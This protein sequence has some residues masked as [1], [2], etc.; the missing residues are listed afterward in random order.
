[1]LLFQILEGSCTIWAIYIEDE[2]FAIENYP[3]IIVLT[4][5]RRNDHR[6]GPA[7]VLP[8]A[9]GGGGAI[10]NWQARHP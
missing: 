6:S 1:V 10:F 8:L 9:A 3:V 4:A 5:D 7:L 2:D